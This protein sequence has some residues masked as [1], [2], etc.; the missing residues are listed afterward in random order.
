MRDFVRAF[1]AAAA[2]PWNG[3]PHHQDNPSA[4]VRRGLFGPL[5]AG[6]LLYLVR[7]REIHVLRVLWLELPPDD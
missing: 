4:E 6:L 5:G 1:D 7:E 3:A 2:A